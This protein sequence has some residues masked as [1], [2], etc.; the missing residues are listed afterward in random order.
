MEEILLLEEEVNDYQENLKRLEST[1]QSESNNNEPY[2]NLDLAS[3]SRRVS[4][5]VIDLFI[6]FLIG[7]T[8]FAL[9][10]L[11]SGNTFQTTALNGSGVV[12]STCLILSFLASTYLI[13][14]NAYCGTS[15]GKLLLK[16]KI[17]KEDGDEI[18]V[19]DS[20]VRWIGY[21]ISVLPMFY[22]FISAKFDKENQTW[23]DKLAGTKVVKN[24]GVSHKAFSVE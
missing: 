18:G 17:I 23:H 8:T 10:N 24:E 14:I 7:I 3:F 2:K 16:I 12:V 20:F 21:F 19:V 1:S 15:I 11:I 9:G 13:F 5:F 4:A 6:I 22:G